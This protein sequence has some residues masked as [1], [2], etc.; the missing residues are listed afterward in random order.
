MEEN[1]GGLFWGVKPESSIQHPHCHLSGKEVPSP[2]RKHRADERPD[3]LPCRLTQATLGFL[4]PA[5]HGWGFSSS[6]E[7]FNFIFVFVFDSIDRRE[8]VIYNHLISQRAG[9]SEQCGKTHSIGVKPGVKC[10]NNNNRKK[11]IPW[12]YHS[13]ELS[14]SLLQ[15]PWRRLVLSCGWFAAKKTRFLFF[16][17]FGTLWQRRE[18]RTLFAVCQHER[19]EDNKTWSL[20]SSSW[21]CL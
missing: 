4:E 12:I 18:D 9:S 6:E 19:R 2:L 8:R 21:T 11:N 1:G 7:V 5:N 13:S 14:S 10:V 16:P 20:T 15:Q 17:S 3:G